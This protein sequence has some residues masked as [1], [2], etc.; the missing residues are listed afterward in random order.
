MR[1]MAALWLAAAIVC[2]FSACAARSDAITVI[3]REEGSGTRSAF[4]ALC[5]LAENAV[6]P[7]AEVS[8]STAVVLQSVLLDPNA[9]GYLSLSAVPKDVRALAIEGVLP[10]A[11][12]VRDGSYPLSR[13]FY[14][15]FA[16]APTP[17][18]EDFLR[19]LFSA[20]GQETVARAG[21]VSGTDTGA[22]V[23]AHPQGTV[24]VG[25]SSSVAPVI[26]KLAEDYER[27]NPSAMI[28]LQI[29]DSSTGIRSAQEGLCELAISSRALSEE[30]AAAG[31][32][33]LALCRDAVAVIV[34]PS[35]PC[36]GLDRGQLRRIYAGDITRW[37]ELTEGR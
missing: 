14:V 2:L 20:E 36:E 1:R 37:S 9:V 22:F 29:S 27:R 35:N 15:A 33:A 24:T 18:T 8:S 3:S 25:G 13:V 17:V 4:N 30:E 7:T 32:R 16:H 19:Y 28:R 26:E 31:V 23:S 11:Q 10:A 34:H 12:A 21:Y 5:G 6:T